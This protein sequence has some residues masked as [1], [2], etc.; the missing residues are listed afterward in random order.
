MPL[1]RRISRA[2]WGEIEELIN[3]SDVSADAIT[4]CL[5]TYNNNLSVWY[6][7][8]VNDLEKAILALITG[9]DQD[10]LSTLH[11][12]I[13]D[14]DVAMK[15]GLTLANTDGNTVVKGLVDTHRDL[16]N[17]TY[18]KLGIVKDLIIDCLGKDEVQQ[19][20]K[21]KLKEIITKALNER[22]LEISDLNEELIKNEKLQ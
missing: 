5:R 14:E 6:I 22:I 18:T 19:F 2:K 12:V 21:R 20:T 7:E 16:T 17:L 4:N 11:I 1:I 9:K 8:S 13:I 15:K 10:K 3:N